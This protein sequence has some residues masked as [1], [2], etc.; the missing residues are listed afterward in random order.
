MLTMGWVEV[1]LYAIVGAA[2]QLLR[3]VGPPIAQL[4]VEFENLMLFRPTDRV[5]VYV[6]V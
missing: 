6:R 2:R 5:L 3:Y 1:V 4:L